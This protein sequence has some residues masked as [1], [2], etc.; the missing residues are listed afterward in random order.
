MALQIGTRTELVHRQETPS[1]TSF[2][3][4]EVYPVNSGEPLKNLS[5]GFPPGAV[6]DVSVHS[7]QNGRT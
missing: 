2:Y 3:A 5:Q 6:G 1:E 4:F 7:H